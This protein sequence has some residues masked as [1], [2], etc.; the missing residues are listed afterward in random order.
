M[1]KSKYLCAAKLIKSALVSIWHLLNEVRRQKGHQQIKS[2]FLMHTKVSL[3]EAHTQVEQ[4]SEDRYQKKRL[5][6]HFL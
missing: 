4:D 6:N 2:I 5:I 3:P 1:I